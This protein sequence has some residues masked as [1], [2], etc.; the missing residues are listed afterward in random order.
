MHRLL[1]VVAL[2]VLAGCSS[3]PE[4][5]DP[6]PLERI[7]EKVELNAVESTS[8]GGGDQTGLSPAT[9]GEV[10]AAASAGGDVYLFNLNLEEQWSVDIEQ[11]IVGGV[12]VNQDVVFVVT[13]DANLVALSRANGELLFEI[14]L[15]SNSM[16]P[17]IATDTQVFIKTQIGQLLA[18]NVDT[19]ETIWFEEARETGVGIRGGAPMTLEGGILY[20][21]WE[22]GRIVAYQAESGRILW[23]RQVAVSHGRGPLEQIVDSKGA[24]S[25]RNNLVATAT[26]NA[27][28]SLLDARNGQLMWSLD[29]DAYPGAL[30]A[31]NAVTIVET[32]GTISAY[33]AQSGESLWTNEALKYRE[34]SPPAV[35]VD[36]IGVVDLEGEMHLLDPANGS[37]IG[38]LDVGGDKGKVA[39]VIVQG[40]VLVQLLDGRLSRVEVIR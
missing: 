35:I 20:V 31:F 33:S 1:I 25:V 3:A 27:Q 26:R 6:T 37:I 30:L 39:P 14:A 11:T 10:I 21:L 13:S 24:P 9:D 12:A 17:P 36:S 29:A 7:T 15:P 4:K 40:G 38:R 22:S 34:L 8:L 28:V 23:E 18:L 32:D 16:V 2:V 19:G 5:P